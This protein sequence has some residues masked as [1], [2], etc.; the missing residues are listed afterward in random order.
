MIAEREEPMRFMKW[1]VPL[2]AFMMGALPAAAQVRQV[3]LE[4]AVRLGLEHSPEIRM[5]RPD[6]AKAEEEKLS[7]GLAMGPRLGIEAGIQ[8]WDHATKV[9]LIDAGSMT[10]TADQI[11]AIQGLLGDGFVSLLSKLGDP[12]ETQKR[13]T[14]SFNIQAVQ[15][16]T[17]LYSLAS[18][19]RMQ[20]AALEATKLEVV[21]KQQQVKFR[22]ADTFFKL[23]SALR[24][25]EVTQQAVE[26]VQ[27]HL[28]TAKAYNEAGLVGRDDVLRAETMLAKIEDQHNQ[29]LSGVA[30][31]RAGLAVQM[32]ISW[33]TMLMPVGDYPDPPPE[34]SLSEEKAMDKALAQRPEFG[35]VEWRGRMAD[36]GY[37]ASIGALIPTIA[38]IFRYTNFRGSTFQ[39]ENSYFVG[40][41]LT[42]N[43]FD[44]GRDFLK[45]KSVGHDVEKAREG[46]SGVRDQI[47]LDV[48]RAW[49]DM[50]TAR[51]SLA[52]NRSAI[53]S[54]DEALRVVT[55]K[56]EASTATSV[57][58]LDAQSALNQARGG[59]A[60]ALYTY[61][62]AYANIERATGGA[63]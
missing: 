31:A 18:L 3:S 60:V 50:T 27:A 8:Y 34:I 54:A 53:V 15:P 10:L 25:T 11:A 43:F 7:A 14:S 62:S 17:P 36:E 29:A 56:Y 32:G 37:Q 55:R 57:E 2:L 35:A 13:V 39:R 45:M 47:R 30:M 59:Y 48:K 4:E 5:A 19:Y 21:A 52:Y 6:V 22:I 42:W 33:S 20:G 26:Q 28:K 9:K 38:G 49:L 58:V 24:L 63:M 1:V 23:M 44:F 51:S 46:L 61:Y 16:L 12:M 40:A 41:V